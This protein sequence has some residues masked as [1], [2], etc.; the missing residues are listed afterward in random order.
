MCTESRRCSCPPVTRRRV[1]KTVTDGV[2]VPQNLIGDGKIFVVPVEDAIRIRTKSVV[3]SFSKF[4]GLGTVANGR[5]IHAGRL[6]F[7][8]RGL[9]C[10]GHKQT[11]HGGNGNMVIINST[12]RQAFHQL[13]PGNADSEMALGEEVE[14][15]ADVAETI[16][17]TVGFGGRSVGWYYAILT[18][19]AAGD[20]RVCERQRYL[21]TRHTA[22]VMLL[23]GMVG[24]EAAQ[25]WPLAA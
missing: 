17:G 19:D 20:F 15:F 8:I 12:G 1:S 2:L 13:L 16:I 22:R 14:W 4:T 11:S 9:D 7:R 24:I 10:L 21:P 6:P 23:R 5:W 25:A 18:R 3:E